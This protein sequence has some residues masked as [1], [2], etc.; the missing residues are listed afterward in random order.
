MD[1]ITTTT[2]VNPVRQR[3]QHDMMMRGLGPQTQHYYIRH[4]RRLAAFP[5]RLAEREADLL[6]VGYFHVVFTLPAEIADTAFQNKAVIYDLLFKAASVNEEAQPARGACEHRMMTI[7]ADPKHL[8][9][10]IGITAVLH[11]WGSAMAH[12]PHV[13]MIVPGGGTVLG[14]DRW[15]SPRPAFLRHLSPVR[16]KRW[17]EMAKVPAIRR[18]VGKPSEGVYAKP[19]S[20]V[21]K[22]CKP[23]CCVAPAASRYRTGG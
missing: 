9:T 1:M 7:A 5:G 13:Y 18:I 19:P 6:P 17:A 2:R 3:M 10:R 21:P 14:G 8:G 23:I 11:T 16:K 22:R 12:H 4:F 15:I 20:V